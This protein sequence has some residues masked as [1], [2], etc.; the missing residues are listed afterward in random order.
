MTFNNTDNF[1]IPTKGI[2]AKGKIEYAGL[3]SGDRLAK[4]IKSSLKFAAYYGLEDQIGYDVI[5]RYKTQIAYIH[6]LGFTPDAE[7]LRIGGYYRGVRGY[8][9][10]SIHPDGGGGMKS[11]VNSAEVSIG[12]SKKQQ[13][14]LTAFAD[15]G[16][17][18]NH[19]FGEIKKKSIGAQIEWRSPLGDI[20]FIFAKAIGA[21]KTDRTSSFE[22]TIGKEF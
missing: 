9:G 16:M 20:N 10:A 2:Y 22:F 21:N 18:G 15:Y 14:R 6:D 4:Y 13:V 11:W 8:R 1:Y 12:L 3:G 19:S 7:K 5:L 17:I